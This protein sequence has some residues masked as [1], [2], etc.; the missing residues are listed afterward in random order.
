[1]RK[2]DFTGCPYNRLSE[3]KTMFGMADFYHFGEKRKEVVSQA[4]I[5]MDKSAG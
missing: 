4:K 1:M 3:A 2:S 5:K